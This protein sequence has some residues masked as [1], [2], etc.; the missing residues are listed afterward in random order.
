MSTFFFP[1]Y[2]PILML[3][4]LH[5]NEEEI[6]SAIIE[7]YVEW[8]SEIDNLSF[9]EAING[10]TAEMG[11]S[12]DSMSTEICY[13]LSMKVEDQAQRQIVLSNGARVAASDVEL[14]QE[15]GTKLAK[16]YSLKMRENLERM[17][18]EK[19]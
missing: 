14:V 16:E 18:G 3:L 2:D 15:K 12:G 13:L 4:D 8:A 17:V 9:G 10:R 7:D 5:D 6:E 1:L 11:R 19:M